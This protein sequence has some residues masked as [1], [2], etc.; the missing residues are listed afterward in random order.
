MALYDNRHWL[1][2]HVKNS[3]ISSDDTGMCEAVIIDDIPKDS[4]LFGQYDK[5]PNVDDSSGEDD[6][7][8]NSQDI[9]TDSDCGAHRYRTNTAQRL[10]KMEKELKK[11]AQIKHI[12]WENPPIF[13]I[14]NELVFDKKE[15]PDMKEPVKSLLS[16]QLD[17]CPSLPRN[18]FV[19]FAKFGGQAQIGM[20]TRV[21]KVFLTML[22]QPDRNYPLSVCVLSSARMFELVGYIC[23]K[24]T[25]DN[26]D[27]LFQFKENVNRYGLFIAEDDGEVDWDFSCLDP[28]ENVGKFGLAYL[29]LVE[30]PE[31]DVQVDSKPEEP[32]PTPARKPVG[33]APDQLLENDDLKQIR[34]DLTAIEALLYQ[35]FIVYIISK[36]RFNFNYL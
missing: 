18:P 21:Y 9:Y 11:A 5:Y 13:R 26:P 20:P 8:N 1:L 6:E 31:K 32:V 17:K 27:A 14:D 36:V 25:T 28:K 10:I 22:S 19:E 2:S 33:K 7:F 34:G 30:L 23:W 3:F 4:S 16:F 24:Y 35:S 12:K 29:A 15:V